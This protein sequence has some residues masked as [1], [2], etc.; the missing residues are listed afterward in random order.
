MNFVY[1]RFITASVVVGQ[2]RNNGAFHVPAA[3]KVFAAASP[4][5]LKYA[6]DAAFALSSSL[7]LR[8]E[9]CSDLMRRRYLLLIRGFLHRIFDTVDPMIRKTGVVAQIITVSQFGNISRFCS[10]LELVRGSWIR[11]CISAFI[12]TSYDRYLRG[13]TQSLVAD[14]N[15][16]RLKELKQA[17]R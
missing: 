13:N 5:R 17:R 8:A 11:V 12:Y 10:L 7:F 15:A 2:C 14:E 16:V 9:E 1:A 4:V 6:L 3:A